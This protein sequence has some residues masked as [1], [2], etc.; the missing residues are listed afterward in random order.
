MSEPERLKAYTWITQNAWYGI[1]IIH[2]RAIDSY[3]IHQATLMAMKKAFMHV[4][5]SCPQTPSCLVID[6]MELKLSDT[7]Y[8]H[9]PVYAFYKGESLSDS[10]AAASIVAKVTRDTLMTNYNTMF[11]HY[12]FDEHKGYATQKHKTAL[13]DRPS[14]L[15]HRTTFLKEPDNGGQQTI[16]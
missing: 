1:G 8:A 10:I 4:T 13:A 14:S 16:C 2:H 12:Y 11:P 15:I 7:S 6:A 3:N 9:V 5:A